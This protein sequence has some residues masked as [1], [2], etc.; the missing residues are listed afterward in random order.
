MDE[1]VVEDREAALRSIS[2]LF[3]ALSSNKGISSMWLYS[4]IT[5]TDE[6][7]QVLADAALNNRQLHELTIMEMDGCFYC[8]I[9]RPSAALDLSLTTTYFS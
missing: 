3:M 1:S 9:S 8:R 6:D 2:N 7:C 5:L 4:M